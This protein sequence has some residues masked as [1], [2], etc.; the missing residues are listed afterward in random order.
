MSREKQKYNK[1]LITGKI[2][3]LLRK[4][5]H[6]GYDEI[7]NLFHYVDRS[8][9]VTYYRIYKEM[10]GSSGSLQHKEEK[11][12]PVLKK[13]I[14]YFSKH[15]DHTIKDAMKNLN[16]TRN[17]ISGAIYRAKKINIDISYCKEMPNPVLHSMSYKIREY[18]MKHPYATSKEC[19]QET[20]IETKY[21]SLIRYR[22]RKNAN[23]IK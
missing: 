2:R 23:T 14:S 7:W 11:E 16:M 18:F 8:I 6:A 4:N 17:Q 21:I 13:I 1:N 12:R 22:D 15:P 20:G 10:F 19:H 9:R 5:P 3:N